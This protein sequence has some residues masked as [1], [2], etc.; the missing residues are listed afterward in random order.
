MVE[1]VLF[2]YT[3]GLL[4]EN[5]FNRHSCVHFTCYIHSLQKPEAITTSNRSS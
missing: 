4:I 2:R 1:F 3:F 5:N